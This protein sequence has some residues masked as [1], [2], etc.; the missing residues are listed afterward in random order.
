VTPTLTV[1]EGGSRHPVIHKIW[2]LV[3]QSNG[4]DVTDLFGTVGTHIFIAMA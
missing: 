4:E 3:E 1:K 2:K